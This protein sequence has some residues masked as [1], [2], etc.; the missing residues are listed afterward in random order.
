MSLQRLCYMNRREHD[1][2]SYQTT[3]KIKAKMKY[4]QYFCRYESETFSNHT[5]ESNYERVI[6][7]EM[8][9][10]FETRRRAN[11]KIQAC[12]YR[13]DYCQC[14]NWQ[15]NDQSLQESYD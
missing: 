7:D 12:A 3:R 11:C 4:L 14:K 8:N 13:L 1:R 2:W 15:R 10:N 5:K 6:C 9:Q